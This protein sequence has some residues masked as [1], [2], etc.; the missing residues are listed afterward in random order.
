MEGFADTELSSIE[1]V[2]DGIVAKKKV[3]RP[4]GSAEKSRLPDVGNEK[5]SLGGISPGFR[6]ARHFVTLSGD[7][8]QQPIRRMITLIAGLFLLVHYRRL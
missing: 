4:R 8:Q 7:D 2:S 6:L 3:A 5:D 1:V